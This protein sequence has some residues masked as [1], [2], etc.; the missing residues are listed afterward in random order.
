MTT[1]FIPCGGLGNLLF[2]HHAA[3]AFAK[4]HN[5]SLAAPG[6]YPEWRP[7]LY[8]YSK[9]FKHMKILGN[10]KYS[11]K[12]AHFDFD[13][14]YFRASAAVDLSGEFMLY[15]EPSFKYSPI[16]DSARVLQGY[17]QSWKYFDKYRTEIRDL[18]RQNENDL[19]L[20]QKSKF[21]G[22]ICVHIRWGGDGLSDK[23]NNV[24]PILTEN[25]YSKAMKNF[26]GC[27]FLVFCEEPELVKNLDIWKDKNVEIINES[28]P[29]ATLFLMSCCD[30][31]IIASSTL[32]LM[33]YY[34]RDQDAATITAPGNW[35]NTKVVDFDIND[36]VDKGTI[37]YS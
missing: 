12:H 5:L 30:H 4:D 8:T 31:F 27:K 13:P 23:Y 9:L 19:W 25:Y 26:E 36:L 11:Q 28:D 14:D 24:I 3:Y 20:K 22:G 15:K 2:Q 37:I 17:F 34:M 6:Y 21:Q 33:A 10:E 32:S 16:P 7:Q 29:L 35:F 18:L 1:V